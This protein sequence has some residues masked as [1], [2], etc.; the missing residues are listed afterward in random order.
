MVPEIPDAPTR[1]DAEASLARLDRLLDGYDFVDDGGVSRSVALA[2]LMTQVLRCAMPVQPAA[3]P[4]RR[5]HPAPASR[6]SSIC[7]ATSR[8]A[9]G[10]RS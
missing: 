4:Y 3:R 9:A 7:A 6:T 10:A 1:A 8:S 2:M 5:P